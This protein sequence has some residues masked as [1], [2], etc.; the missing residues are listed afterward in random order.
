M[1]LKCPTLP[2][3]QVCLNGVVHARH[4]HYT[5]NVWRT[6]SIV[7]AVPILLIVLRLVADAHTID[8]CTHRP[9]ARVETLKSANMAE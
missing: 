8:G 1:R 4:L 9:P 3:Q 2:E 5:P 7:A 6:L